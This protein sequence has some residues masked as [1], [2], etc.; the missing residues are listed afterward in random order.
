[1]LE[2]EFLEEIRDRGNG[3]TLDNGLKYKLQINIGI[4]KKKNVLI[5]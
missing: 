3:K 1:M 5:A 2:M 4:L